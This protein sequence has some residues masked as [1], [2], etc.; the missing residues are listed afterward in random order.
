MC[1]SDFELESILPAGLD[2]GYDEQYPELSGTKEHG[3]EYSDDT[4]EYGT[5][6]SAF[7][8]RPKRPQARG[9]YFFSKFDM[10]KYVQTC[11][12][13]RLRCGHV[14]VAAKVRIGGGV[15]ARRGRRTSAT[16]GWIS[17]TRAGWRTGGAEPNW[18]RSLRNRAGNE[19]KFE[20]S[21]SWRR[22][23]LGLGHFPC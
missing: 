11:I 14:Q 12:A 6:Y 20:V 10:A 23:R 18:P 7:R 22:L 2:D 1:I 9:K 16:A 4:D 21:Q 3:T 5:D 19:G 15:M 8:S 17:P 13:G